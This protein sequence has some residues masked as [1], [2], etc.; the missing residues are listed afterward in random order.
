MTDR[1]LLQLM[2]AAHEREVKELDERLARD[3]ASWSPLAR[4]RT[5]IEEQRRL[6][7]ILPIRFPNPAAWAAD[8]AE[9]LDVR[10][11]APDHDLEWRLVQDNGKILLRIRTKDQSFQDRLVKYQLR[12]SEGENAVS[13]FVVLRQTENDWY[14]ARAA[15]S[16]EDLYTPLKGECQGVQIESV[17]PD[18]LTATDRV[19][20]AVSVTRSQGDEEQQRLL[21][22][23]LERLPR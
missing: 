6:G 23:L 9:R 22:E 19:A 18:Q 11:A 1:E 20:L 2:R 8:T 12:A 15:F 21:D 10:G 4:A 3:R 16:L 17:N 7:Q 13:G 5:A 14:A